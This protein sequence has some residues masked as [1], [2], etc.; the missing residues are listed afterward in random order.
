MAKKRKRR[1][2]PSIQVRSNKGRKF[3]SKSGIHMP[4]GSL[5]GALRRAA[6]GQMVRMKVRR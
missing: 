5:V 6:K 1:D 2:A 4:L 3:S